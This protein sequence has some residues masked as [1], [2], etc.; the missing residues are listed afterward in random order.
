MQATVTI[1]DAGGPLR[2]HEGSLSLLHGRMGPTACGRRNR[3]PSERRF[4]KPCKELGIRLEIGYCPPSVTVWIIN[5]IW[6]YIALNRTP[7][8]DCYW[9]GGSTQVRN[10][11]GPPSIYS[12]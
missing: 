12:R 9:G 2:T 4:Y 6:F 5:M 3:V 1:T 8:I 10:S 11:H 7:S